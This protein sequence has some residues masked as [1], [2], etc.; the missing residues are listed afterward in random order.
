MNNRDINNWIIKANN[1]LKTAHDL[2]NNENPVT[3][4]S[5]SCS[6]IC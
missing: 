6:T 1:H 2:F 5:F 3:D 4:A